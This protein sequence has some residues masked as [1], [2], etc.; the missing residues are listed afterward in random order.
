MTAVE[1]SRLKRFET[2]AGTL[3][4]LSG[5]SAHDLTVSSGGTLNVLGTTISAVL[6]Q[7]GGTENISAGG[8]GSGSNA[9]SGLGTRVFGTLNVFSGRQGP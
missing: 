7:A 8:T 6:V 4:L 3:N 1:D 9:T 2:D 5:G